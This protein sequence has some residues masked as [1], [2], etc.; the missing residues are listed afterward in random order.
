MDDPWGSN[1][2][3]T[4]SEEGQDVSKRSVVTRWTAFERDA[5]EETADVAAPTWSEVTEPMWDGGVNLWNA[6]S[7]T[8]GE[9][10]PPASP[11]PKS[12]EGGE[13]QM[14]EAS[15][16]T[17]AVSAGNAV[18]EHTVRIPSP[19][20]IL[21]TPPLS[22]PPVFIPRSHSPPVEEVAPPEVQLVSQDPFG[23]FESA[24]TADKDLLDEPWSSGATEFPPEATE[25][26]GNTWSTTAEERNKFTRDD[27]DEWELAQ[28]AKRKR[29]RKVVCFLLHVY[30]YVRSLCPTA[31]RVTE[32]ITR[33]MGNCC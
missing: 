9:W 33:T 10:K 13:D 31:A 6:S 27:A 21:P 7:S 25:P 22:P 8:Q 12:D 32:F 3:S 1:A 23:S 19:R 14:S 30:S 5:D 17:A 11:R 29:D 18:L 20:P 2:W 16:E 28:E 15:Q 4:P 26:W 24:E